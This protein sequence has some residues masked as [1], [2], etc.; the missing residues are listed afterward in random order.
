MVSTVDISI[1]IPSYNRGRSVCDTVQKCLHLNPM[2]REIVIVD[3][4][5]DEASAAVLRTLEQG[6]VKYIRLPENQG[7]ATARSVGF[8]TARGKYLVSLDDDSWFVDGDALQGV[9][10]RLE[11]QPDCGILAFRAFSPGVPVEPGRERLSCVA[12]H[13]ACGAAYRARV[14]RTTGYHVPFMRYMGEEADLTVKVIGAGFDVVLDESIR[15]FHD[16]DPVKRSRASLARARRFAVRNDLLRDWIYFPVDVAVA[17]TVWQTASHLIFA[18]R[19]GFLSATARGYL[20]FMLR[21]PQA[22]LHR[23]PVTRGA[24]WRYLRLRHR[25]EIQ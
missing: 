3:D 15:V 21:F 5:S 19:N 24:A 14:L 13:I 22:L 10:N 16:Y 4:C 17:V 8:A 11:A 12:D 20:E 1:V 2:P 23:R 6:I 18:L 25:P 7:Q 9:W